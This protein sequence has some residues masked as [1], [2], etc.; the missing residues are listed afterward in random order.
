MK[1]HQFNMAIKFCSECMKENIFRLLR[2]H[3][4]SNLCSYH[5]NKKL[6]YQKIDKNQK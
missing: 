4:K 1:F 2:N 3:N 5:L 6:S